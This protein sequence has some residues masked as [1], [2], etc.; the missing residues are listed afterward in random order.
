MEKIKQY[1]KKWPWVYTKLQR[2]YYRCLY[3]GEKTFLGTRIHEWTWRYFPKFS[4]K[5]LQES[6]KHPHRKYLIK[7]IEKYSAFGKVLEVGCNAGQN[8][9][10]LAKKL[11]DTEFYGIDINPQFIEAG[12]KWL[13]DEGL[14][15][16]SLSVERADCMDAFQDK[17]FDVVFTDAVLM[18]IGVDKINLVFQE[19][20]RVANKAIL[21]NEWHRESSNLSE[22]SYWYDFHWVHDYRLYLQK[23]LPHDKISITK[24]PR[25]LWGGPGWEEY[26]SIIEVDLR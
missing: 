4:I 22:Q 10:L 17:S 16:V 19:M 26:G 15:N 14:K 8:L 11:P 3:Y 6:V 7:R 13:A 1:L 25:G 24:L 5:E 12:E 9:Y 2:L 20:I 23:L 21:L 18:Y